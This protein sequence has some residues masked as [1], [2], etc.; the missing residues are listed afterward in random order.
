MCFIF[1][2]QE[3]YTILQQIMRLTNKS[4]NNHW[5]KPGSFCSAFSDRLSTVPFTTFKTGWKRASN[6]QSACHKANMSNLPTQGI[7]LSHSES[8]PRKTRYKQG[9]EV[10]AKGEQM[11]P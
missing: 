9:A 7:L 10:K 3:A 6:P 2:K 5:K 11:K 4:L 1:F 8:S